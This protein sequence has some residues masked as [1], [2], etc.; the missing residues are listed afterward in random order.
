MDTVNTQAERGR[1]LIVLMHDT[2]SK[3]KT[4]EMLSDAID[5]IRSLGYTFATLENK[6]ME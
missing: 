6:P 2:N 3:G 4:V 5:Y 1:D